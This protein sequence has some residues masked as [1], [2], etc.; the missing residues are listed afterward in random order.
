MSELVELYLDTKDRSSDST[1]STDLIIPLKRTF[2]DVRKAKLD[3]VIIPNT[4]FNINSTNNILSF[5]E[6]STNK[7]ATLTSGAYTASSLA[8][9]VQTQLNTA[10]SGYNTYAVTYS[11]TTYKFTISAGN[12]FSLLFSSAL[13]PYRELGFEITNTTASTSVTSTN[14]IS[15]ER[16]TSVFLGIKELQKGVYTSSGITSASFIVPLTSSQGELC[17][18]EPNHHECEVIFTSPI[19]FTSLHIRLFDSA[20]TTV[21]VN[22]SNWSFKLSL[23]IAQPDLICGC[24]GDKKRKLAQ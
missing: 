5:N 9:H 2:K 1:S 21:N 15:L 23:F 17:F 19:P 16:P 4:V 20:G 10:S 14:S 24:C 18:Y 7:Q 8:T 22:G 3:W 12:N 13:A 6:N 11:T